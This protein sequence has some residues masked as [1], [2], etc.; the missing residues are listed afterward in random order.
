MRQAGGPW[1]R[2][3]DRRPA[4]RRRDIGRR[5]R[6]RGSVGR[7]RRGQGG[8]RVPESRGLGVARSALVGG[9][10]QGLDDR[11]PAP[12]RGERPLAGQ[13]LE[14]HDAEAVDV[15]PAV[16][17]FRSALGESMEV[18]RRHVV[19][20]PSQRVGVGGRAVACDRLARQVEVQQH[21]H[22]VGGDQHVGRLDVAV[23]HATIV[24]MARGPRPA[25]LPT[26][27]WPGHTSGASAPPARPTGRPV[28]RRPARVDRSPRPGRCP[29][30]TS[31]PG[32]P[33]APAPAWC[34]RSRACRG[35]GGPVARSIRWECTGTMWVCWSRA[36]VCGSREPRRVTF[37]ATGRSAN[38]RSRARK[39]RANAPRPSSSTR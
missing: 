30:R 32:S 19:D 36:R 4:R 12:G 20:G 3:G 6:A 1:K 27:R 29:E 13:G 33:R 37:S 11:R 25:G 14:E 39:T 18:L 35:D 38:C 10:E 15:G 23:E 26:R 24:G 17:G 22:A 21:G 9:P 28:R 8:S 34:G 5:D 7:S 31:C 16:D 2:P